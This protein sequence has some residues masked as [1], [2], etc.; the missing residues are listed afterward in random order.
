VRR[1]TIGARAA[2]GT[3]TNDAW[4]YSDLVNAATTIYAGYDTRNYYRAD[5]GELTVTRTIET[6]SA[7]VE[8]FVGALVEHAWSVVRD[9]L[10]GSAPYSLFGRDDAVEG[11]RRPNPAVTGGTIASGLVGVRAQRPV[12]P[13]TA[14][15]AIRVEGPVAAPG[16]RRF[17]QITGD[18]HLSFPTFRDQR[19]QAFAHLVSTSGDRAPSQRYAYIGGAA[20]V[21]T[22]RLLEQGGD[23]LLWIESRYAIPIGGLRLPVVGSPTVMLRHILGGAGVDH[24]P[25]LTQNVGL[26]VSVAMLRADIVLDP[27]QP[28]RHRFGVGLSAR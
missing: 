24:L 11:M 7:F 4:V 21:P 6:T 12:G 9:S 14:S 22:L 23:D 2:R 18:G 17:V 15:G 20:T 5:R 19:F 8:P 3:Y 13:I 1:L 28:R 27:A 25:A 26:R 16:V 10:A